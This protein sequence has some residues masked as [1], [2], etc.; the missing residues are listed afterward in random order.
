MGLLCV[1]SFGVPWWRSAG[2]MIHGDCFHGLLMWGCSVRWLI[3]CGHCLLFACGLSV[4]CGVTLVFRHW[5][6]VTFVFD[7]QE[8]LCPYLLHLKHLT[9]GHRLSEW[10]CG[11]H[12]LHVY[13][14]QSL[15]IC[16]ALKHR[17][18]TFACPLFESQ[19]YGV[20][21]S[22]HSYRVG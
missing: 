14:G 9:C 10:H 3:G 11:P 8:A 2:C 22:S 12:P 20:T 15:I 18:H 16:S 6:G 19:V 21:R 13:W 7:T 4:R 17:L 1:F 5:C